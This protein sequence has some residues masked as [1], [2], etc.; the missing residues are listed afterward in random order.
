M[1]GHTKTEDIVRLTTHIQRQILKKLFL[2]RNLV[3]FIFILKENTI[4]GLKGFSLKLK[5]VKVKAIVIKL[6]GGNVS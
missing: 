6:F 3:N 1:K 4:K 5:S 2:G